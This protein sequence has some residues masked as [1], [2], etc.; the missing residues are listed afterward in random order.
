MRGFETLTEGLLLPSFIMYSDQWKK[1]SAMNKSFKSVD[2]AYAVPPHMT[3]FVCKKL[4]REAVTSRCCKTSFCD[5]CIRRNLLDKGLECPKCKAKMKPD[6]LDANYDL[7]REA[8][9]FLRKQADGD[10]SPA[11][12]PTPA[13]PASSTASTRERDRPEE[14]GVHSGRTRDR[15]RSPARRN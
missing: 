9:L 4:V 13:P 12:A 1:L 5:E 11:V 14:R 2:S 15:S 10:P 7:R 8:E 3:C 6:Q